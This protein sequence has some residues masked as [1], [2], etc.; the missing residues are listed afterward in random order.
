MV[1]NLTTDFKGKVII[2]TLVITTKVLEIT[3]RVGEDEMTPGGF[4]I[5]HI[6]K[7]EICHDGSVYTR[8]YIDDPGRSK[9]DNELGYGIF[10]NWA[11][12]KA[13]DTIDL[14]PAKM[15][16]DWA[17]NENINLKWLGVG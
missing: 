11:E 15:I 1:R 7:V 5:P 9:N 12:F 13:F 14:A 10:H 16:E 3:F 6:V 17:K 8:E 4:S 2:M